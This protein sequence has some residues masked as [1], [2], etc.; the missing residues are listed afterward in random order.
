VETNGKRRRQIGVA[1]ALAA[2]VISGTG[3]CAKG[4]STSATAQAP[5]PNQVLQN[6]L[7]AGDPNQAPYPEQWLAANPAAAAARVSDE[8]RLLIPTSG[9]LANVE[10]TATFVFPTGAVAIDYKLLSKPQDFV[11]QQYIEIHEDAW[12]DSA[13]PADV[14]KQDLID[15]PNPSK[16]VTTVDGIP[17]LAVAPYSK[18]DDQQANPAFLRLVINGIEVEVSGGDDLDS[19]IAI[20]ESLVTYS[21]S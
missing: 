4:G 15:D 5:T 11:R 14:W 19:L 12:T 1:L 7:G 20:A 13:S 10:P 16:S 18:L 21:K 17:A 9:P 3:S 6:V 8:Y 2:V